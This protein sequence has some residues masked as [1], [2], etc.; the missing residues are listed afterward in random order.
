L[1]TIVAIRTSDGV[2]LGCDSQNTE[3]SR[4][5]KETMSKATKIDEHTVLAC[6]GVNNYIEL[7]KEQIRKRFDEERANLKLYET[8]NNAVKSFSREFLDFSKGRTGGYDVDRNSYPE[9]IFAAYDVANGGQYRIFRIEPPSPCVEL[10]SPQD[11]VTAG[12]GGSAASVLLK[13]VEHLMVESNL[14]WTELPAKLVGQF[15]WVLI[16]TVSLIDPYTSGIEIYHLNGSDVK[17]FSEGQLFDNLKPG[18]AHIIGAARTALVHFRNKNQDK[19]I[20]ENLIK[21]YNAEDLIRE[22]LI[23]LNER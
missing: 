7:L 1:T 20:I 5:I 2:I 4:G 12:T 18:E 11:E 22:V 14:K 23:S 8:L 3:E 9:A 19:G 13:T 10:R 21:H 16:N 6:A 15:C 17:Q